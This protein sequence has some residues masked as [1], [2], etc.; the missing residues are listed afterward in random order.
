MPVGIVPESFLG[1]LAAF[2]P[3]FGAPSYRTFELLIVGW[4]HCLGRRT[5]T[6]V[7]L[8][9]GAA[10]SRHISVFH[11]FFSR[12]A[13]V[14]DD[15]GRV[16]FGLAAAWIPAGQPLYLVIDD[17]LARKGGKGVALA[18]MHHDPLLSTARK[19]FFSF[20]HVWVVLALWVPLPMGGQRGFALP[21]LFRLYVGGKRGG[22]R[23]APSRATTGTRLR[24]A[25]A[26]HP[27]ASKRPT[28][29]E[30][31]REMVDLVATWAGDR[32]VYA[33]V[34]SAYAGQEL[35]RRRPANVHVVSRL[36]MDA[37]LWTRPRRRRPGQIGR[38]R[39]RGKRVPAPQVLA[40]AWRRWR[41]LPVTLYGRQVS[42][43]VFALTA[44]WYAALPEHPVRIVVVRDPTGRRQ[45]EA[46]FCTDRDA[47]DA[48]ILEGYARRWTLEV[49]FHDAKQHLG[50]ADPQAQAPSAVRRTAPV[51]GLVY[52]LVLLWYADH[53]HPDVVPGHRPTAWPDRPWYRAKA[54]PS[55]P[56]IL[57]ALRRAGWRRYLSAPPSPPRR[58]QNPAFSWP[59]AV[60]ATA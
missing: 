10:G 53:V 60:L 44:L 51:A 30:L 15:L 17:T 13:W 27:P 9:S 26:A 32:L 14:V 19:P 39:K 36:R 6:A 59:D 35:L 29:L 56:D 34:D 40:A 55:F 58:H 45:D 24:A 20:G 16:V 57:A 33:I 38:P 12:A 25:Q 7:A 37:A 3:C 50:L 5:I 8:A 48:F 43:L 2:A 28:K 21:I 42:P 41:P 4:V 47:T 18:S 46:F 54:A 52:A 22:Q 23:D 31:A 11:R 49:T 1:L